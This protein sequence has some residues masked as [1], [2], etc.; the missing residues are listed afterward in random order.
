MYHI[1]NSKKIM[2]SKA[3]RAAQKR[4]SRAE[5]WNSNTNTTTRRDEEKEEQ[6]ERRG[7]KEEEED[8]GEEEDYKKGEGEKKAVAYRSRSLSRESV[9]NVSGGPMANFRMLEVKKKH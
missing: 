9:Q 1:M 6:E 4:S 2:D 7:A 3:G 8:V 5:E